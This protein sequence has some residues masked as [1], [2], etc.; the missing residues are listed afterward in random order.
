[1][2]NLIL[3]GLVCAVILVTGACAPPPTNLEKVQAGLAAAQ[4]KV[5]GLQGQI[6]AKDIDLTSAKAKLSQIQAKIA[7][8]KEY[9][10]T[11][12]S[13]NISGADLKAY[14]DKIRDKINASGDQT[15]ISG[16]KTAETAGTVDALK[17]YLQSVL[18]SALQAA[19]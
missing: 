10:N 1:M 14:Y 6:A 18:D 2:R 16:L 13:I 3:A 15:L 12:G 17:S 19:K 4:E 11:P 8:F 7:V 9:F 5:D